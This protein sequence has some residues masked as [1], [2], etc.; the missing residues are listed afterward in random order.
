M[1]LAS[2]ISQLVGASYVRQCFR[3]NHIFILFY[4]ICYIIYKRMWILPKEGA[5]WTCNSSLPILESIYL[6]CKRRNQI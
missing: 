6:P 3:L 5:E 4:S 1:S 2:Q